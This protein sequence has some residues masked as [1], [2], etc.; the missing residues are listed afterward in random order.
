MRLVQK[1][2]REP[3][4]GTPSP[5]SHRVLDMATRSG[6]QVTFFGDET[7][8]LE[9]GKRA[10]M[11]LLNLENI[12]EPY[13]DPDTDIVDALIYRGRGSDVD[14]VI[15][16]GAVLL[17]DGKHAKVDRAEVASQLRES[18]AGPLKPSEIARADLNRDLK[19]YIERS[20][21]AS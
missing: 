19:P 5:S 11:V 16:D 15:V 3:G 7:G 10:D 17:R 1:I 2:H 21:S 14:T 6:A 4:V 8:T 12:S 9:P 18:L 13:L 20:T